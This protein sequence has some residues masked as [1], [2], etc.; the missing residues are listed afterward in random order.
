MRNGLKLWQKT[1]G[2]FILP[3]AV[4]GWYACLSDGAAG[5]AEYFTSLLILAGFVW[6]GALA[7]AGIDWARTRRSPFE[8]FFDG[9]FAWYYRKRCWFRFAMIFG[10]AWILFILMAA[11]IAVAVGAKEEARLLFSAKGGLVL[12]ILLAVLTIEGA[13]LGGLVD[14][15]RLVFKKKV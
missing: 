2:I 8:P 15:L 3:G 4:V 7:G 10:T 5:P 9:R 14:L 1:A 6:L 12:L 13:M 11:G